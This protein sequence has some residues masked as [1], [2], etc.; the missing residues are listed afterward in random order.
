[1]KEND[2]EKNPEEIEENCMIKLEKKSREY[3][4]ST[5]SLVRDMNENSAK[6][7]IE[8]KL[9]KIIEEQKRNEE[10]KKEKDDRQKELGSN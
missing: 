4:E 6:E 2:F 5:N 1:M 8:K 10:N 3:L 7:K 9:N